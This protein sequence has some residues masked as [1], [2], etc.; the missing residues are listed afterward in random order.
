MALSRRLLVQ[1][2]LDVRKSHRWSRTARPSST[3]T[4]IPEATGFRCALFVQ[5]RRPDDAQVDTAAQLY[6]VRHAN[7]SPAA[8]NIDSLAPALHVGEAVTHRQPQGIACRTSP[9]RV[10]IAHLRFSDPLREAHSEQP[11]GCGERSF[12]R[13]E[14]RFQCDLAGISQT[15]GVTAGT[16][17]A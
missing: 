11:R 9:F 3:R 4:T 12:G 10:V 6:M 13:R 1:R 2:G 14:V 15:R 16:G 17:L 7:Q 5:S 8:A